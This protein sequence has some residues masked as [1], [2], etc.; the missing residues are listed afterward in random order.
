MAVKRAIY[1][2]LPEEELCKFHELFCWW[3][4][5]LLRTVTTYKCDPW[6]EKIFWYTKKCNFC[7]K[8]SDLTVLFFDLIYITCYFFSKCLY[9]VSRPS[10]KAVH[11]NRVNLVHGN[12]SKTGKNCWLLNDFSRGIPLHAVSKCTI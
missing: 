8:T 5:W 9:V 2:Y 12:G 10:N 1:Y 6:S 3:T 7:V 4:A 11:V